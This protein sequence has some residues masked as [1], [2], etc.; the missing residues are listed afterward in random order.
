MM[1][2]EEIAQQT[3]HRPWPLRGGPWIMFQ[4]WQQ[5]L[6]AHWRVPVA[7]LRPLVPRQ[8]TL[9]EFDGTA[10]VGLTPFLLTGLHPRFLPPF[11]GISEFPEMN[12][13]TY[14][15]VGEKPGIFFFSLDA[16][17]RLAVIGARIGYQLP[18]FPSRM[19]MSLR[20]GWFHY[21]SVR[22]GGAAVFEGKYRP[23]GVPTVSRPGTL[24]Y[25]LTERYALY[26]VMR[27]G[28]VLR[29]QIHHGPWYL[30]EAEAVIARN[31]VADA[32]GIRLPD[33]P[34]LL[35]FSARQDTLIWPPEWLGG[36]S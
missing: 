30:Q 31:T 4:S 14:V 12:L 17:N 25:F 15:R 18:Y 36:G 11:P 22:A 34:P 28:T 20:E 10:W 7:E 16:A 21:S 3:A 23:R 8:L 2:K 19:S 27:G 29:G 1:R 24:E 33:T 9:E 13:R 5:L 35:H 6:F 32:A 26:T